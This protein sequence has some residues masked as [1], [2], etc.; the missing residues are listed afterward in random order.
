[1]QDIKILIVE[2]DLIIARSI[3]LVLTGEG[4]QVCSIAISYDEAMDVT[5]NE[6]PDI[7]IMDI[8]LKGVDG[9]HTA[10]AIKKISDAAIIYCTEL[11]DKHSF[12]LA[13]ET[14]PAHY[15]TKPFTNDELSRAVALA[16]Q[17]KQR[18][19]YEDPGPDSFL[20]DIKGVFRR[21]R[22][23]DILYIKA[24]GPYTEIVTDSGKP[25][26]VAISSNH[27]IRK[28]ACPFIVRAHRSYHINIGKIDSLHIHKAIIRGAEIP[29]TAQYKDAIFSRFRML[30]KNSR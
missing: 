23:N 16:A 15:L 5:R 6:S 1:M 8:N 14:F 11:T 25:V 28:I 2:D 17:Q 29:I 12:N 27:V 24:N 30:T 10:K 7:V 13:K 22:F 9:I 26:T 20:V 18:H 19:S 4:Y 3:K 21:I